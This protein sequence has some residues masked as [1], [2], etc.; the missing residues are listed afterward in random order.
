MITLKYIMHIVLLLHNIA[1][2]L[3]LL[4]TTHRSVARYTR[5]MYEESASYDTYTNIMYEKMPNMIRTRV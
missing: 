1:G 5:I 2:Y 4:S 3:N